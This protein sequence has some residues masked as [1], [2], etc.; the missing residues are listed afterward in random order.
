MSEASGIAQP[1]DIPPALDWVMTETERQLLA[2]LLDPDRD[3]S[4]VAR[5]LM[6]DALSD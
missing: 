1:G 6:D 5:R 2:L 3:A 4:E